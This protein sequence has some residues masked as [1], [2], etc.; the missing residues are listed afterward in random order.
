MKTKGVA[1]S[2]TGSV[3]DI[4]IVE[5][6]RTIQS[7]A[8]NAL[9]DRWCDLWP[10]LSQRAGP[11]TPTQMKFSW[12]RTMVAFCIFYYFVFN[13]ETI[14]IFDGVWSLKIQQFECSRL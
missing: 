14:L 10:Q 2:T 6:S 12:P 13:N 1:E 3:T 7:W 9:G 8:L 5:V 11:E 4:T